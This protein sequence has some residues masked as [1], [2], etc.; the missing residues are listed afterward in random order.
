MILLTN[1]NKNN[2][3]NIIKS[4]IESGNQISFFYGNEELGQVKY[5]TENSIKAEFKESEF[6][7]SYI[8]INLISKSESNDCFLDFDSNVKNI[9]T[10]D[11][12]ISLIV[13]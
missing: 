5:V 4:L 7:I 10:E 8:T 12:T 13:E 9:C 6:F 11:S 3:L 1:E 2:V